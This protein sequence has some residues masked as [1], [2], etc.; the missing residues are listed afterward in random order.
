MNMENEQPKW[1]Q[2][3]SGET[4]K[5]SINK[6]KSRLHYLLNENPGYIICPICKGSYDTIYEDKWNNSMMVISCPL[7]KGKLIVDWVTN[8]MKGKY[9]DYKAYK[10]E[11]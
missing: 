4:S 2:Q 7:C 5:N 3:Q 1:V 11:N 8:I 6:E 9:A 10:E